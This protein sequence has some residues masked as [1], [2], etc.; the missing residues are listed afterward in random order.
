MLPDRRVSQ[1]RAPPSMHD[2]E[3]EGTLVLIVDDHPTNRMVLKRQVNLLGYACESAEDGAEAMQAWR[4][5]RFSAVIT[6]CN[7][8]ILDGYELARGIRELEREREGR[9]TPIIA[10]TANAMASEAAAC[11]EAGMDDYLVKPVTLAD[12]A[13]QL[14]RWIPL[15][16]HA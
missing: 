16:M 7:M 14:E 1:R 5:G 6:D 13:K 9:R 8:P 10:C 11:I 3:A 4:S 2:A 15:A 12:L